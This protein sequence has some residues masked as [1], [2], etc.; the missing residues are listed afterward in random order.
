MKH[1]VRR[2]TIIGFALAL[3]ALGS[4]RAVARDD[5]FEPWTAVASTGTV[6][7]GDLLYVLL[8]SPLYGDVRIR[9]LV[10]APAS[11]HLRYNIVA[12]D[13]LLMQKDGYWLKARFRDTGDAEQIVLKLFQY[14]FD[15]GIVQTLLTLDS[16]DFPAAAGYQVRTMDTVGQC[17]DHD[18]FDF[19]N[20]AYFVEATVKKTGATGN[21]VL[22]LVQVGSFTCL[23]PFPQD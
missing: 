6:D 5:F 15:S 21:P 22:S 8:G 20:N 4:L 10:R 9:D 23:P 14:N 18:A 7:E 17:L 11:I 16:N 1:P 2:L 12:V 3:V 19:F 13:G